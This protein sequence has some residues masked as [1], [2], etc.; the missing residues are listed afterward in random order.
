MIADESANHFL[1]VQCRAWLRPV[2]GPVGGTSS[3]EPTAQQLAA[4]V[5]RIE[6]RSLRDPVPWPAGSGV[7]IADQLFP[8]QCSAWLRAG[9]PP[10]PPV[11]P[12]AQQSLLDEQLTLVSTLTAPGPVPS[13]SGTL[14]ERQALPFQRSSS[15][16]ST[17]SR[18]G[19]AML[20]NP[21]AQQLAGDVQAR[22]N[23]SSP[24]PGLVPPG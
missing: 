2:A 21:A 12:T 20:R 22:P 18:P 4:E 3:V 1:P 23:S 10:V 6:F 24:C 7:L 13:G 5:H 17:V 8:F 14:A 11:W 19:A 16:T 15:F 9:W